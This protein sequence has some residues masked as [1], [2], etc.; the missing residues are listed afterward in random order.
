M[1]FSHLS[2]S[3][4]IDRCVSATK[5]IKRNQRY[6]IS[7]CSQSDDSGQVSLVKIDAATEALAHR[8]ES[9]SAVV[10]PR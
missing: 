8:V 1:G 6:S 7:D 10:A 4:N 5:L 3:S 9:V 2:P